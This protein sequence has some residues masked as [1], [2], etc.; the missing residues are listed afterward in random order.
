VSEKLEQQQKTTAITMAAASKGIAAATL[1][2][3]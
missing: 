1:D 3:S 2:V